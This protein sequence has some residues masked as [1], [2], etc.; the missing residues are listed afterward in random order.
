M[1]AAR[2]SESPATGRILPFHARF[3]RVM[4]IT[5]NRDFAG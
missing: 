1:A 3:R 2:E 5:C 4:Q